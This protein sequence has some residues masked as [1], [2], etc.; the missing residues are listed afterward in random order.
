[1]IGYVARDKSGELYIHGEKPHYEDKYDG[2]FSTPDNLNITDEFSEFDDLDYT[3]KP[4]KVEIKLE[5][6]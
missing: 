4:V 6:V 3:D 2:W 5:K 1:M